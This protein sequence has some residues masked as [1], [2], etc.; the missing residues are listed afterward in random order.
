MEIHQLRHVLAAAENSSYAQAAKRCFT[1]RQNIAQSV[2]AVETELGV[3]LFRRKGNEMVLTATGERFAV[4]AHDIIAKVDGLHV[5]FAKPGA[6]DEVL[7]LAVS[8]NLFAGI[9]LGTDEYIAQHADRLRMSEMDCEE[10]YR[11]ICTG[12]A[13]VAVIMCMERRF[14]DCDSLEIAESSAFALMCDSSP[15]S[16][17][18][19]LSVVD[20][21]DQKLLLMSEPPFQYEPL[22]VQLD[23]L[24]F[25]RANAS[26]V[27]STSSM[28]HLVKRRGSVGFVSDKFSAAPPAGFR[29]I[30]LSDSRLNWRF[31][32][33]FRKSSAS[34]KA[35]ARFAQDIQG[36][37]SGSGESARRK[38]DGKGNLA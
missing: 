22:F 11:A 21:K 8:T 4:E 13:D 2:K 16:R 20:M 32:L 35:V 9:P 24:G 29:A 23:S 1:S 27:P 14:R 7:N 18:T 3:S 33:L 28:I 37:F 5:M 36:T 17:K 30:P 19:S 38:R 10:C 31:Y 25:D 26:V 6:S 12:R 34:F 15:L